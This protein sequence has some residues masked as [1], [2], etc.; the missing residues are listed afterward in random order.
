MEAAGLDVDPALRASRVSSPTSSGLEAAEKLLA[1]KRTPTA[2]FASNDDMAAAAISVAHRRSLDVPQ[3]SV[4]RRFRRHA[5][6]HHGLARAHHHPPADRRDGRSRDQ[7]AAAQDPAQE[8]RRAG[9]AG[10][11]PRCPRARE[12]RLRRAAAQALSSN[13]HLARRTAP[14]SASALLS[15]TAITTLPRPLNGGRGRARR[16]AG[17]DI[18]EVARAQC[19]RRPQAP[20]PR[21]T[22]RSSTG[23]RS[24][25]RWAVCCSVT[26]PP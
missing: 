16:L 17:H 24:S 18:K 13:A 10:R 7:S 15:D 6:R 8:G 12:A 9:R 14:A 2:I 26:T 21:Q 5:D 11:S 4:G 25:P 19:I 23:S 3:R 22:A 20:W 1:R